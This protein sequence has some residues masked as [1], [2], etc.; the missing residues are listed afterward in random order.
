LLVFQ[1]MSWKWFSSFCF[2]L[3]DWE[4]NE[5]S[6]LTVNTLRTLKIGNFKSASEYLTPTFC[7]APVRQFAIGSIVESNLDFF[8][9]FTSINSTLK[10]PYNERLSDILI[11]FYQSDVIFVSTLFWLAQN[12]IS[13]ISF[14]KSWK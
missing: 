1:E 8:T 5:K 14:S 2:L 7:Y 12:W 9:L 4:S 10:S 3:I 13:F 11:K 6:R